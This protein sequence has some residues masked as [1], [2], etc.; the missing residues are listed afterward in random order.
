MAKQGVGP[1]SGMNPEHH[2]HVSPTPKM[3]VGVLRWG[4]MIFRVLCPATS[5]RS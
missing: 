1:A 5:S 4:H 2:G 3:P